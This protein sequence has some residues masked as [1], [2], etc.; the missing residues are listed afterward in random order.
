[1][2]HDNVVNQSSRYSL[3]GKESS[4]GHKHWLLVYVGYGCQILSVNNLHMICNKHG[5]I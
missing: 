1:M 2:T 5:Q 3:G 4:N